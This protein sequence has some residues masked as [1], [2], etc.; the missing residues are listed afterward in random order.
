MQDSLL[1]PPKR[2]TVMDNDIERILINREQIA[3]RVAELADDIARTYKDIGGEGLTL[4]SILSGSI[5]FLSDLIRHLPMKMRI[6]VI[7]VSSYPGA[8]TSSRG[9]K[10]QEQQLDIDLV[11]QHV[12]IVDD[13]LD[14]GQT[15]DLVQQTLRARG[16]ASLRTCV[17]LRKP[18]KAASH[19]MADFVGFDIENVFVVGYGLDYNDHYRNWPDIGVLRPELYR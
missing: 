10:L 8:S 4:V 3:R 11:G 16:P 18:G 19:V 5:I 6:G 14:T 15:L 7:T 2:K 9:P 17:L 13:I 12:L 1:Y